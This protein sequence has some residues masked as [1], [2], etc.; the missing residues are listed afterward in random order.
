MTNEEMRDWMGE[1][2]AEVKDKLDKIET[3]QKECNLKVTAI[4]GTVREHRLNIK[5]I[6]LIFG[7]AWA[8]FLIWFREWVRRGGN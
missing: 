8:V 5:A 3:V 6:W 7:S 4:N 2:F 1:R